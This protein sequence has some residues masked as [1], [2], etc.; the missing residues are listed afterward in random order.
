MSEQQEIAILTWRGRLSRREVVRRALALGVGLP[1]GGALLTACGQADDSDVPPVTRVPVEG[2]PTE[3]PP[4]SDAATG[5]EP[6]E[7]APAEG[8]DQAAAPAGGGAPAG[9]APVELTSPGISWEPK[10]LTVP[11]GGSI[12]IINDGSGG[13]HNFVVTA[14]N[15]TDELTP[16]LDL[17]SGYD[18]IYTLPPDL[19]PGTY[20]Y[21]CTI[22]GHTA[23]MTGTLT[24][25][26]AQA[27]AAPAPSGQQAASP[28][29]AGDQAVA[30]GQPA[31]PAAG[32]PVELTAPGIMW[33]PNELTVPVGGS[34]HITN[35]GDGG[36]HNFVVKDPN[37][38]EELTPLLDL[39]I[40]ADETYTL[41]PEL[42]PGAYNF[43]C[44][45]AGHE[46]LMTGKLTVQ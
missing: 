27:A 29:P 1:V 10:Q 11:V 40:G 20:N 3:A 4:G 46:A 35:P 5:D 24:V 44:T 7:G 32:G 28:A 36:I 38:G 41:P 19:A 34:I 21:L 22:P 33:D 31:A 39:P 9:G 30:A 14:L 37:T 8:S 45:I 13:P 12:R 15:T 26:E 16:L 43:V 17:P 25:T 18:D 6:M 23:N 2:A 42:G